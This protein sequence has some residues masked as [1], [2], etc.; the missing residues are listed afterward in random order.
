[1]QIVGY[2]CAINIMLNFKCNGSHSKYNWAVCCVWMNHD[3]HATFCKYLLGSSKPKVLK[4]G[5]NKDIKM[6]IIC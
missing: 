5:L 3:V 1:M 6:Y 4:S 2:H